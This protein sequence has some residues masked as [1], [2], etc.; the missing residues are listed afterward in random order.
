M[1]TV[2]TT[3]ERLRHWL[4][5]DQA[6]RERMCL[7]ILGIDRNYSDAVPR[8]P[9]GGPDGGR[10]IE[11]VRLGT[12]CFG[13]VGFRNNVSDSPADK[14][15]IRQK[16]RSDVKAARAADSD[17]KAFVFFC[18]VDF[19]PA[20]LTELQTFAN[21]HGFSQVDI[22]WRE[23]I[24][25]ALNGAEGLA[26]RYQY[27]EIELSAA[28]QSAF[29]SR[30]GKDLEDLVRGRFDRIERKLDEV[31]FHRWKAGTI[32]SLELSVTLHRR[33][34]TSQMSPEHFRI[35]LSLQGVHSEH[36][37]IEFGVRDHYLS[38]NDGSKSYR[39]KTFFW[40]ENGGQKME[41][42]WVLQNVWGSSGGGVGQIVANLRWQQRS[43]IPCE[44]FEDL[45]AYLHISE[46][47]HNNIARVAFSIDDYLFVDRKA[48][49]EVHLP[50]NPRF[51]WPAELTEKEQSVRWCMLDCGSVRMD[52]LPE[53]MR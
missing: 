19:T 40:Q 5:S 51:G 1:N 27:L 4:N 22:Y 38:Q 29:F 14:R 17:V 23:R 49:G 45:S 34:A 11:C 32:R 13:A 42:S 6:R 46:N 52:R 37:S 33:I 44:A 48:F 41:D 8:R 16:F 21:K 43:Q 31:E 20:E 26:I 50:C 18:N 53:I 39:I 7:A 15:E 25:N 2:K 3:D 12:R 10:D 30:Y 28:E 47:L 24:R 35:C 36:R 9:E